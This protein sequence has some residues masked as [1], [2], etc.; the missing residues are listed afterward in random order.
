MAAP[1]TTVNI[2]DLREGGVKHAFV[3]V[4]D[5]WYPVGMLATSDG[6][7]VDG[8]PLTLTSP[9]DQGEPN[10][11]GADS[12]PVLIE[13]G[14]HITF[15]AKADAAAAGDTSTASYMA[16]FKRL[17]QRVSVFITT[18]TD[19][20]QKTQVSQ[21][22]ATTTAT[23]NLAAGALSKV[24]TQTTAFRLVSVGIKFSA[25]VTQ[26]VQVKYTSPDGTAYDFL[27]DSTNLVVNS[28]Y[29]ISWE[30]LVFVS[31]GQITVTCTNTGTPAATAN[32]TITTV[33]V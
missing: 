13:D 23:Q 24:T 5:V 10:G 26:T 31:G 33:P 21:P 29:F 2:P 27:L 18:L 6:Q 28:S 12:W 7:V 30:N 16:L 3:R 32:L 25:N 9:V 19:G 20:S 22:A 4:G 11:G 8:L 17:L 1:N 14:N 15:G